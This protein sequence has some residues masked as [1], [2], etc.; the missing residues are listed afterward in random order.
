MI[1]VYP[2][3]TSGATVA[4]NSGLLSK[5]REAVQ[6][7]PEDQE[8]EKVAQQ[9]TEIL[10]QKLVKRIQDLGMPAQPSSAAVP[11]QGS[12]LAIEGQI[13]SIDEGNPTR[14]MLIGLGAGASE[15]RTLVQVYAVTGGSR[16][17]VEDFYTTVKSSRKPGMGPMGGVGAAAGRAAT[18]VAVSAGVGLATERSQTVEGDAKHTADEI[19]KVLKKFFAEQG[20][21]SPE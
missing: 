16:R 8:R 14:R 2:F 17:L 15:V 5:L 7:T 18:S 19:A 21:V 6:A 20:W 1:V 12:T 9:V 13:L 4:L 11:A 10:A 3:V